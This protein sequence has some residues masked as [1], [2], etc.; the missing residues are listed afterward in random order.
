MYSYFSFPPMIFGVNFHSVMTNDLDIYDTIKKISVKCKKNALVWTNA[1]TIVDH[2][3]IAN[4]LFALFL[5]CN[6]YW[7]RLVTHTKYLDGAYLFIEIIFF[8]PNILKFDRC[9]MIPNVVIISTS[10]MSFSW[11]RSIVLLCT[12]T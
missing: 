5:F 4:C 6:N 7:L 9:S 8:L 11:S 2:S 3:F 1:M 10:I 12:T